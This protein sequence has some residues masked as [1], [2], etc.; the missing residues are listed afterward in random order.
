MSRSRQWTS[1]GELLNNELLHIWTERQSSVLFVTH[2]IEEAVFLSDLVM[3]MSS[4]PGRFVEEVEIDLPVPA[5]MTCGYPPEI[6]ATKKVL[7]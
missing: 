2:H 3:V 1:S 7:A 4:A 5:P 6:P